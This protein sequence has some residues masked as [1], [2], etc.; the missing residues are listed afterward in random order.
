MHSPL[1]TKAERRKE[2]SRLVGE[3]RQALEQADRHRAAGRHEI[4]DGLLK[5]CRTI[6]ERID[7]HVLEDKQLAARV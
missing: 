1:L 5:T 2:F 7:A 6:Q 4:A 3:H